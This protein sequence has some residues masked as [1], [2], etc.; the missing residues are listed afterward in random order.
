MAANKKYLKRTDIVIEGNTATWDIRLDGDING[1]YVGTFRFKCFLSPTQKLAASREYRQLLGENPTLILKHEDNLAF[2]LSQLK[3]RVISA[4]PFWTSTAQLSG[5][6]GDI[7][8]ENIIDAVLDAAIDAELKYVAH[9]QKK[10]TES[11][12]KAKKAA[13]RMLAQHDEEAEDESESEEA[14]SQP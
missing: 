8:D 10:K 13:E 3:Y 14:G 6:A 12:E 2:A 5:M 4:P 11:I 7:P 9:L 1:T